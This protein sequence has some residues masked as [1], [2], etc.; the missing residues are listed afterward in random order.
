MRQPVYWSEI[1]KKRKAKE[2]NIAELERKAKEYAK[3]HAETAGLNYDEIVAHAQ[4]TMQGQDP[5]LQ[6]VE[7]G[8]EEEPLPPGWAIAHDASGRPY[9]WH[10]KTQKTTWDR[11]TAETPTS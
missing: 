8:K 4:A 5:T 10:K 9:Y 3:S 2:V 11:P 1:M 6:L 7:A